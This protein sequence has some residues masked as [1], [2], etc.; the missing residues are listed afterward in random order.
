MNLNPTT[1]PAPRASIARRLLRWGLVFLVATSLVAAALGVL[2]WEGLAHWTDAQ[3]AGLSITINGRDV[4]S[5]WDISDWSPAD[6]LQLIAI[7]AA[8]LLAALLALP[9]ALLAGM[10]ALLL[11]MVGTVGLPLLITLLIAVPIVLA[12]LSPLILV[13]WWLVRRIGAPHAGPAT[14]TRPVEA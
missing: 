11:V 10:A 2:A 1:M 14:A 7:L 8:A 5:E 3:G 6:K 13:A 4:L 9:I 12:V